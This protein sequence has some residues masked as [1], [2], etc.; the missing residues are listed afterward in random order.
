MRSSALLVVCV[1]L[2]GIGPTLAQ[3]VLLDAD[4]LEELTAAGRNGFFLSG[5]NIGVGNVGSGHIG[6]GM[7]GRGRVGIGWPP[8]SGGGCGCGSA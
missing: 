1:P 4:R 2:G 8:F 5:K 7:K 6:I 3:P